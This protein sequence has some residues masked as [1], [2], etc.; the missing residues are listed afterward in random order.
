LSQEYIGSHDLHALSLLHSTAKARIEYLDAA[1]RE[2]LQMLSRSPL[3]IE[4]M[5]LD[6]LPPL[7]N[8]LTPIA[9][10]YGRTPALE[11]L[12]FKPGWSFTVAPVT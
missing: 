3:A 6:R 11:H 9:A 4:K 5:M 12:F 10:R 8:L 2:P 7:S 1:A